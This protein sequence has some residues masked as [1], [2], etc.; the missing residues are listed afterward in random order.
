LVKRTS[1]L[2]LVTYKRAHQPGQLFRV[3]V[4]TVFGIINQKDF[5]PVETKKTS[6]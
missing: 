3:H 5:I 6:M 2:K 1:V 4:N